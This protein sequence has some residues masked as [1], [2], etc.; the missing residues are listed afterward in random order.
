MLTPLP[1]PAHSEPQRLTPGAVSVGSLASGSPL[2]SARERTVGAQKGEDGDVRVFLPPP[3][4]C[5]LHLPTKHTAPVRGPLHADN[6]AS[7]GVLSASPPLA[8][9][10]TGQ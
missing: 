3:G 1:F 7:F 9:S 5:W 6:C 10:V 8:P 2:D 4:D